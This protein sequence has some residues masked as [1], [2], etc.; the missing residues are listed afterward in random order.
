MIQWPKLSPYIEL[1]QA[2]FLGKICRNAGT[3]RREPASLTAGGSASLKLSDRHRWVAS[4]LTLRSGGGVEVS[5]VL[6]NILRACLMARGNENRQES[7]GDD[8]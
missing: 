6:R 3:R 8:T 7:Q 4:S 2:S 1:R 5:P